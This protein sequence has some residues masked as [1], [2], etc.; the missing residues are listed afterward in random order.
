MHSL[1]AGKVKN[2]K[3]KQNKAQK[4]ELLLVSSCETIFDFGEI[5]FPK[6]ADASWSS[7]RLSVRVD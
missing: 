3:Q 7:R 2:K 6:K 4:E 1:C 5:P